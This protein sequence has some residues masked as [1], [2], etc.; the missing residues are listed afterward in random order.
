MTAVA[1]SDA[2]SYARESETFYTPMSATDQ[3]RAHEDAGRMTGAGTLAARLRAGLA[4]EPDLGERLA[5]AETSVC[6]TA[7]ED[8]AVTLLLDRIPVEIRLGDEPTEVRIE[9]P[10]GDL[11]R[12]ADGTLVLPLALVAG[13]GRH[14]GPVRRLLAVS[15]ILRSLLAAGRAEEAGR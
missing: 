12:L 10:E 3:H 7:G 14:C 2:G 15:P 6:L 8:D 4:R 9:L 13:A 1:Y 5:F 11:A